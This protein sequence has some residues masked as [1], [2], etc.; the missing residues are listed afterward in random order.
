MKTAHF[1]AVAAFALAPLPASAQAVAVPAAAK[2]ADGFK[3][4]TDATILKIQAIRTDGAPLS[5]GD[6]ALARKIAMV[7]ISQLVSSGPAS[8]KAVSGDVLL[9]AQ[10]EVIEQDAIAAKLGEIAGDTE[11]PKKL[12]DAAAQARLDK[13]V[14]APGAS[15]GEVY[16][17]RTAIDG[18][19]LQLRT[20]QETAT[21]AR[22]PALRELAAA[23]IPLVEVQIRVAKSQLAGRK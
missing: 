9:I 13:E 20:M 19:L 12:D 7:G 15:R 14:S 10:A 2:S 1:L 16:L 3:E 5:A 17:S 18:N 6:A 4:L 11:L 22:N 21:A 8:F 23:V